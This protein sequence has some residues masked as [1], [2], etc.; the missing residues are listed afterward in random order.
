[1]AAPVD[2]ILLSYNRLDYLTAMVDSI[3]QGTR[4]PHRLTVVD[5]ASG[6]ATRQWLREHAARFHQIIWNDSNEHLAGFQRGIEA[7]TSDLF[8]I[9]DADLLV[10]EPGADGCWLERLVALAERHPDFALLGVRLDSVSDARNARLE[11]APLIDGEILETPTGVWLNL[12]RRRALRVPYVSDGITCHALRRAGYRVGIA[13]EVRATHLG[14]ADPQRHPDY[15]ARK[16]AASG[17]TTTYPDYPELAASAPPPTLL[18]LALAAPL[19]AALER[20][21]IALADTVE[22]GAPDA[23]LAVAEPRIASYSR[24]QPAAGGAG[25]VAVLSPRGSDAETRARAFALAEEWVVLLDS[26][27][28]PQAPPGW[29]LLG[30]YPGSHPVIARLAGLASR[31]RWR[32]RLLYSTSEYREQWLAVFRAGCFGDD[33]PLRVYVFR[34]AEAQRRAPTGDSSQPVI[35]SRDAT[36]ASPPGPAIHVPHRRF[37]T[38]ATKARRLIQAEWRLARARRHER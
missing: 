5:N 17:W 26:P 3:E 10:A 16:Q 19:L 22:L 24:D 9:S 28:V 20:N 21:G 23:L 11:G 6:P 1:V 27:V 36:P 12:I 34:R 25:A 7:T 32:R 15:L 30:E 14:D 37:A 33:L 31:P 2:I 35:D 4:W 8:V 18:T 13:A 29:A 38:L